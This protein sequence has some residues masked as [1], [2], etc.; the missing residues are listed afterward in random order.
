MKRDLWILAFGLVIGL[1]AAGILYLASGRPRGQPV[2]ISPPPTPAP[3]MVSI[4]GGVARP[5]LYTLPIDSRVQD[6][7]EAAGGLITEANGV[8]INLAARL[9]DG[10]LLIIPTRAPTHSPAAGAEA[11]DTRSQTLPQAILP[12]SIAPV[13]TGLVNVNTASLEELDTLPGIGPVTA[14]KIIDYRTTNGPFQSIEAI[15]DVSGIGPA[16]YARIKDLI[17]VGP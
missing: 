6:A 10:D 12:S 15:M 3:I 5:G 1:F 7:V 2:Q 17:S 9:K 11:G 4:T 13:Q 16:T 8:P 14:Q